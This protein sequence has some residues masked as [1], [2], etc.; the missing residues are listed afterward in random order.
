MIVDNM[1]EDYFGVCTG[2]IKQNGQNRKV[3]I[4]DVINILTDKQ[5]EDFMRG[6][7]K[8]KVP[9]DLFWDHVK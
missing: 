7:F 8:F 4:D 3:E 6:S 1:S 9:N 2:W 5:Y